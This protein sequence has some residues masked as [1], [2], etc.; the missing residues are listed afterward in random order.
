[1]ENENQNRGLPSVEKE[2]RSD[3]KADRWYVSTMNDGYFVIDQK[4]QPAPVDYACDVDHGVK[5]IAACGSN[6]EIAE[7]LVAEHNARI[8]DV[9]FLDCVMCDAPKSFVISPLDPA[10]GYCFKERRAWCVTSLTCATT[11]CLRAKAVF[12]DHCM[13]CLEDRVNAEPVDEGA[14]EEWPDY[15]SSVVSVELSTRCPNCGGKGSIRI[16]RGAFRTTEGCGD[17]G[18]TG[19]IKHSS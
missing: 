18:G 10:V 19:R 14:R 4:P 2:T 1:M 16:G 15:E 9:A 8:A 7:L 3:L 12:G 17:C 11:G 13:G 6:K 5:M